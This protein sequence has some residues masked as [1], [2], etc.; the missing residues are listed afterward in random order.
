MRQRGRGGGAVQAEGGTDEG[1]LEIGQRVDGDRAVLVLEQDRLPGP[2]WVGAHVDAAGGKQPGGEAEPL[3]R[4]VVAARQDHL[5]ASPPQPDQGVVE[6]GD[7]HIVV[8]EV[9]DAH[10]AKPITG[11]PD[12]AI[13]EM[14][15][16]GDNVFY[17]G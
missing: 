2:G 12:A 8:G 7:H 16:L 13:L 4:V 5:G 3:S 11:R 1:R 6:Q 17:G 10:V 15:E 14:K 9:V